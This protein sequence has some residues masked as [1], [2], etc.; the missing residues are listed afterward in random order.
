[1][2]RGSSALRAPATVLASASDVAGSNEF[3]TVPAGAWASV[4]R[5]ETAL[6]TVRASAERVA[7]S[8]LC[9]T[10]HRLK[11]QI[12]KQIAHYCGRPY[13]RST[14]NHGGRGWSFNSLYL[15]LMRAAIASCRGSE[16]LLALHVT[17]IINL[18]PLLRNP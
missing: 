4:L 9:A 5:E 7:S 11:N 2:V 10:V 8:S 15:S 18:H 12:A 16:I 3:G 13:L 6:A 1:M 14:F 17:K